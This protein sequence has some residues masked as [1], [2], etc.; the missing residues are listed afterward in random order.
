MPAPGCLTPCLFPL[1]HSLSA[2]ACPVLQP[3]VKEQ[4]ETYEEES[5]D[6]LAVWV[7]TEG[8]QARCHSS[9]LQHFV[10]TSMCVTSNW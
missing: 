5:V 8:G 3:F 10:H 2:C 4:V 9:I 6:S 1:C 7:T